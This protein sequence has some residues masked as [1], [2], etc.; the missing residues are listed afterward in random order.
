MQLPLLK[1]I[2]R[3]IL[4]L[5]VFLSACAVTETASP[6]VT[7]T[8]PSPT[9]TV[10]ITSTTEIT[11]TITTTIETQSSAGEDK[12]RLVNETYPD[13]SILK[14]GES[15]TKVFEL[16]NTGN[17]V[18]TTGYKLVRDETNPVGET[19]GS[20]TE[21][22]FTQDTVPGETLSLQIPLVAPNKP[23]IYT[24]NWT[25]RDANGEILPIGAA[26]RIWVTI[27]VCPAGQDCSPPTA[28]VGNPYTNGVTFS[29]TGVTH[30]DNT[31]YV[32]ICITVENP[33]FIQYIPTPQSAAL[34]L[35]GKKTFTSG[36]LAVGIPSGGVSCLDFRFDI[37][38]EIYNQATQIS[39]ITEKLEG[40][41]IPQT[42]CNEIR[43][44]LMDQYPG[45]SFDCPLYDYYSNLILPAGMTQEE[46]RQIIIDATTGAIY[47]PWE[48]IIK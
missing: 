15:F 9:A 37:L 38:P 48:V 23:G 25:L 22:S 19:L 12:A 24:V 2:S 5:P 45:L 16:R 32:G 26:Q 29:L 11:P 6:T 35:D 40:N 31:T 46:A 47:G 14:P 28:G 42:S 17:V 8:T 21:M 4:I 10:T 3:L 1:T 13:N 20:Q 33:R 7:V 41:W 39:F 43:P 18:W 34:V 44:T 27:Q 30:D 36:A